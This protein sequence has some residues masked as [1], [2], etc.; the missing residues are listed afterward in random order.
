MFVLAPKPIERADAYPTF[1]RLLDSGGA[2]S[3]LKVHPKTLQKMAC[4][5]EA[6]GVSDR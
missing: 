6:A 3:L 5:G 1:E 2:A 4:K